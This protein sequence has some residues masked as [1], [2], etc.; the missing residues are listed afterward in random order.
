MKAIGL[1]AL[2]TGCLYP[3]GDIPGTHFSW[4]LSRLQS[5]SAAGRFM[6]MENSNDTIGNRTR[7]LPT[8]SAVP[9]P[10][11]PLYAQSRP[12]IAPPLFGAHGSLSTEIPYFTAFRFTAALVITPQ[13]RCIRQRRC[14]C[15]AERE[16][17]V[18]TA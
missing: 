13:I 16:I 14:V 9:Q 15:G 7:D 18:E 4:R 6:S 1:L 3:T 17:W 5:H 8:C 11:A 10:P 12:D 2:C